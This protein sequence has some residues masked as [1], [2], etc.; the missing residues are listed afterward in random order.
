[1]T[2]VTVIYIAIGL[3]YYMRTLVGMFTDLVPPG[4]GLSLYLSKW[5]I[6]PVIIGS[7]AYHRGYGDGYCNHIKYFQD[8]LKS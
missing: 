7:I 4:H 2:D 6:P 5:W 1:M 3:A 8:D